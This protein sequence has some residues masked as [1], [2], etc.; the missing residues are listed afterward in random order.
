MKFSP[1]RTAWSAAV[2]FGAARAP[3]NTASQRAELGEAGFAVPACGCMQ[4]GEPTLWLQQQQPRKRERA[5]RA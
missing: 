3:E 4:V 2:S 1:A 5:K